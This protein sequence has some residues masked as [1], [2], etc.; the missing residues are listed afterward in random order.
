M[1]PQ[2]VSRRRALTTGGALAASGI[3]AA[4]ATN[5]SAATPDTAG[6][7]TIRTAGFGWEL[8]N[9]HNNG[10]DIYF[11]VQDKLILRFLEFDT[12]YMLTAPPPAPGFIEILYTGGVHHG[13]P[14]FG[15]PPQVYEQFPPDGSFGTGVT[16]NPNNL[17]GPFN[18]QLGAGQFLSLIVKS[19]SPV[20][21]T[22][23]SA[24]RHLHTDLYT[25][26]GP[27]DFLAFH[28]DHAG[29]QVDAEVQVIIGY[30]LA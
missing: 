12:S 20:D 13:T 26:V 23:S 6:P 19:W 11:P 15:D 5:A 18:D 14:E 4:Q 10:A 9:I 3:V 29:L 16:N 30:S 7:S 8:E 2:K 27:G 22:A 17:V 24:G 21:G 1:S 28:M 25:P